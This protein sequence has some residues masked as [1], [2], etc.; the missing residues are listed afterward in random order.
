M[1]F[2]SITRLR[3]RS[4]RFL[5]A[6]GLHTTRS[7]AQVR[8]ASGFRRGSL[9]LDRRW[10][11][12]TMTAWERDTDMRGYMQGGA[13]RAAMPYL[14]DWCDQASVVH[15]TEIEQELPAWAEA[16]RRMRQDGRPS[17]LRRASPDHDS[18]DYATP[19]LSLTRAITAARP[20]G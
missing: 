17:K 5:P 14:L 6:F 18:L 13:H 8:K 20:A 15:W 11:F 12:W 9:L 2:I 19:R 1:P 7:L 10:T 4:M 3:I 16:D